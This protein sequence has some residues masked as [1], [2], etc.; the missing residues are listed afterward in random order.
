M[1]VRQAGEMICKRQTMDYRSGP[2]VVSLL[3]KRAFS[4]KVETGIALQSHPFPQKARKWMGARKSKAFFLM[5]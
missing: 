5:V 3:R 2:K 1:I 4:E